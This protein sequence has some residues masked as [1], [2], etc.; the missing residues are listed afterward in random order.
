[1]PFPS[2]AKSGKKQTAVPRFTFRLS[3]RVKTGS[4]SWSFRPTRGQGQ[5][6]H[7]KAQF[8]ALQ[9]QS[10][11]VSHQPQNSRHRAG[12]GSDSLWTFDLGEAKKG[13]GWKQGYTWNTYSR[14][15]KWPSKNRPV[16]S[17]GFSLFLGKMIDCWHKKHGWNE[18]LKEEDLIKTS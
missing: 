3:H 7:L 18:I 1:M 8:T 15:R 6:T 5:G 4:R 11:R 9:A 17:W 2:T 10:G 16:K 14:Q 13:G 12:S